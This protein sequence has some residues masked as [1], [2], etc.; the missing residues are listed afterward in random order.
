MRIRLLILMVTALGSAQAKQ[1]AQPGSQANRG[2]A[3][4]AISMYELEE[5]A[6]KAYDDKH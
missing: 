2:E 3:S 5:K 4:P 1:S 6:S